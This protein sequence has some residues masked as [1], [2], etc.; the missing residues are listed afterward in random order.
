[1][2]PTDESANNATT[3]AVEIKQP[4][5]ETWT[6]WT[7]FWADAIIMLLQ[8]GVDMRIPMR[9]DYGVRALVEMA[10]GDAAVPKQTAQI[11]RRQ[12]IPEA[13]LEQVLT[14]LHKAGLI[15]SRRGPHGGHI[16]AERPEDIDL[17]QV[18]AVLEGR[19]PLL[20]CLVEPVCCELSETCAQREV[21]S[22]F[23]ESVREL[24][25]STTIAS[26]ARRQKELTAQHAAL[27]VH[28]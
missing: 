10:Q 4:A 22:F 11:A 23:E 26:M 8:E 3:T 28:D 27:T 25:S 14:S 1:M 15:K 2:S 20:D 12:G 9:V 18:M 13:Y 21:W 16:L 19:G 6:K 17:S 24:L 5:V 7:S